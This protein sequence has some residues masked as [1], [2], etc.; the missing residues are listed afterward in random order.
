[1][2]RKGMYLINLNKEG[3]KNKKSISNLNEEKKL[4]HI[5]VSYEKKERKSI[6][7]ILHSYMQIG[8]KK[9]KLE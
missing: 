6:A 7:R 5:N 8:K 4:N 3:K 2:K 1:M 9:K